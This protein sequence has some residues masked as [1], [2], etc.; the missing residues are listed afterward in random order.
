MKHDRDRN[1]SNVFF[2]ESKGYSM[3][4]FLRNRSKVLVKETPFNNLKVGDIIV[5][6]SSSQMICHRLVRKLDQGDNKILYVR[7]DAARGLGEPVTEQMLI[8]KVVGITKDNRVIM[9]T[10]KWRKIINILIVRFGPFI[11]EATRLIKRP[12]RPLYYF[13]RDHIRKLN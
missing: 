8:G 13:I 6:R 7:G 4:P 2:I 10:G 5:Y 12:L 3:Y 9:L 11:A 1:N